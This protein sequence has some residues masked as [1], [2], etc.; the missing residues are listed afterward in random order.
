[1][2]TAVLGR[3][4]RTLIPA[5]SGPTQ[6]TTLETVKVNSD[7]DEISATITMPAYRKVADVKTC[8]STTTFGDYG[9]GTLRVPIGIDSH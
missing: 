5:M 6:P 8:H 2:W 7:E 1:M 4:H 9:Y 3:G